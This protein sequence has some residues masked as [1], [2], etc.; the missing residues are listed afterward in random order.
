MCIHFKEPKGDL[1]VKL[2]LLYL[3]SRHNSVKDVHKIFSRDILFF[4]YS[5]YATPAAKRLQ[6]IARNIFKNIGT[7]E[8][9]SMSHFTEHAAIGTGN[10]FDSHNG[11]V[12]IIFAVIG[13]IATKIYI[14]CRNL[15]FRSQFPDLPRLSLQNGLPREK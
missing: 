8:P 11:L 5:K 6:L 7:A 1:C 2:L 10:P 15:S 3:N 13:C 12:R 4:N 14:L 9:F